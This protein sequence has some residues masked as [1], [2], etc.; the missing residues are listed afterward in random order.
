MF[1]VIAKNAS[2]TLKRLV[3]EVDYPDRGPIKD[4]EGIHE[5]FGYSKCGKSRVP[6]VDGSKYHASGYLRFAVYRDPVERFLSVYY[7][8]VSPLREKNKPV[9]KY[10]ALSNVIGVSIDTFID[11]T[12]KEL[13]KEDPM[14]QDEH[15]RCQSACYEP[16]SVDFIVPIEQLDLF[17][18]DEL[19]IET[20]GAFNRSKSGAVTKL[21]QLQKGRVESLYAKDYTLLNAK[22]CYS[23]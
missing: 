16:S 4:T 6:L 12:E 3:Y 10:F 7:D 9:R 17:L 18:L 13:A 23:R 19:G 20:K 21:N 5:F 22:N 1:V 11:F 8:K 15:L 2:T 14:D